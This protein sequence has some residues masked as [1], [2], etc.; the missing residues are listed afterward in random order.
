MK[1]KGIFETGKKITVF[2]VLVA[3][4]CASAAGYVGGK[5][6]SW[7]DERDEVLIAPPVI[8]GWL[9]GWSTVFGMTLCRSVSPFYAGIIALIGPVVHEV[10]HWND[11]YHEFIKRIDL[12]QQRFP[13]TAETMTGDDFLK[14]F[15]GHSGTAGYFLIRFRNGAQLSFLG[16]Y[17][18]PSGGTAAYIIWG[19]CFIG[20]FA[21][22]WFSSRFMAKSIVF[23]PE[24]GEP[25]IR[26]ELGL[27]DGK[28]SLKRIDPAHLTVKDVKNFKLTEKKNGT[29]RVD[30]LHCPA[31]QKCSALTIVKE[32]G[33]FSHSSSD[34][35]FM[36]KRAIKDIESL[37]DAFAP[38]KKD[39]D[40]K[41]H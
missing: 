36:A 7:A 32:G 29:V 26:R 33:L 1:S 15:S 21:V 34:N 12:Y 41:A 18:I 3:L 5:F 6:H 25:V 8:T 24:C 22:A 23:C 14:T 28:K 19:C 2:G 37:A 38:L 27:L 16:K 40:K 10:T 17:R 20:A 31:C 9:A 35:T 11:S 4:F 39:M 13:E 30:A